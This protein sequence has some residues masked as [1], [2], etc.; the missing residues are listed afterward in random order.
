MRL[1]PLTYRAKRIRGKLV[2]VNVY[3]LANVGRAAGAVVVAGAAVSMLGSGVARATVTPCDS[4]TGT[5]STALGPQNW[6]SPADCTIISTG[7]VTFNNTNTNGTHTAMAVTAPNVGTLSNSGT[8]LNSLNTATASVAQ[9]IG[10]ANSGSVTAIL[11]NAGGLIA[12]NYAGS[13]TGSN[14]QF[15]I[16]GLANLSQA[17][18]LGTIGTHS[19]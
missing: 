18:T 15:T 1:V 17:G 13:M 14:N 19:Q 9:A 11:N 4:G 2:W 5:I 3:A 12:G 8:I 10:L 6:S 7:A 16:T